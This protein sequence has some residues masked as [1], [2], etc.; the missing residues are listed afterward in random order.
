MA[1]VTTAPVERSIQS[2]LI[3]GAYAT[4]LAV[5]VNVLLVIAAGMLEIAP[6]FQPISV[7]P[8]VFLSAVGA[9]G[10]TVVYWLLLR[11]TTHPDK[12]FVRV[13][14]VVLVLS[15]VP[16][17]VLLLVDPAA[18]VPGVILLMAMHVVVAGAVI[19]LLVYWKRGDGVRKL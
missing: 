17:V 11:Y 2:V 7:P 8:V 3:R 14:A 1:N 4:V 19:G 12:T 5:A 16:D 13:S 10:A 9:I 18:T 15:F 6:G